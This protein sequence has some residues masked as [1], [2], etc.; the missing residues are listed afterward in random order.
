MRQTPLALALGVA[1]IA[2][3]HAE[4]LPEFV[5]ET[6][7]V[8]P[9]RT[10]QSLDQTLAPVIV[11]TRADIMRLQAKSLIEL[12]SGQAGITLA[13]SGG[14]GMQ[15]SIFMRGSN[16]NHVLVM[17]DGIKIGSA[18]TGAAAF[19]DI[20]VEQIERIE[21]VRGPRSSL[22]GS[23]AI[24][25]VIQIFTRKGGGALQPSVSLTAGSYGTLRATA[26]VS[27][28]GTQAWFN[29]GAGYSETE[30]FD[31]C[32]GAVAGCFA[33]D[34]DRD[35][36]TNQNLNL[37]GGYRFAPGS[38]ID[39]HL[40]R[41]EGETAFDGSIF[42][43]DTGETVQQ[44]MGAGLKL[45]LA[46]HWTLRANVGQ[47]VDKLDLY[48]QGAYNSS[49]H[50][51]RAIYSLQQD[52]AVGRDHLFTLGADHQNDKLDSSTNYSV[53]S[54]D[55][56]GVFAQYQGQFGAHS[57][58]VAMRHDDNSQFG[59][60]RTG[61][62]AWG[63]AFDSGLMFGLGYGTGF[64]APTFNQLHTPFGGNP[65]LQ[66]EESRSLEASLAGKLPG[67]RWQA[68]L[69]DNRIEQLIVGFPAANIARAR[70]RGME[71]TA[72]ARVDAWLL[73]GSLTLQN[74]ETDSGIN[75][76]RVLPRRAQ[77]SLR[78]DIDRSVGPDWQFGA[79]VRVEGERFDNASNSIR[80]A[81]YGLLDL[82]AEYRLARDWKL[83]ASVENLFDKA[84][85]TVYFYNQPGRAG[86]LTVRYQPR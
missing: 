64:S 39:L 62:M 12:L 1:F 66:P 70:I 28:G 18:T 61:N 40:L 8:T 82:R 15:T 51:R 81:G 54:R 65:N 44:S 17:V 71:L 76:G 45:R 23:E 56:T 10:D 83:A 46:P 21:I 48:Y 42:S 68:T 5:G 52:V 77:Q 11:I 31:S 72:N 26:N 22:Y 14:A 43:G 29:L 59:S 69:F 41:A 36:Y 80:L 2:S 79:T 74:P 47:S 16:S 73:A 20:P 53:N 60:Y 32:R 50:T 13:N 55:V 33:N 63:Y 78:L 35:G 4:T 7:V 38:E 6:I 3:A 25:G 37:R 27:G 58:Q 34:P 86:F 75:E 19:Q 9:T 85:E 57:I 67:G 30:G 24:G 49:F 84:Y